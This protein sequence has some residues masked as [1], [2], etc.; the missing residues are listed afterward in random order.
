MIDMGEL[1][2]TEAAELHESAVAASV[3]E[4]APRMPV[5]STASVE[6]ALATIANRR[7][8]NDLSLL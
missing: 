3:A 4:L 7:K 6:G 5:L 1:T 2:N 8:Q